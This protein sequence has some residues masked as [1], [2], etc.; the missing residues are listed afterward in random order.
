MRR[1]RFRGFR[2]ACGNLGAIV[3]QAAH[4]K[5]HNDHGSKHVPVEP[6]IGDNDGHCDPSDELT[7]QRSLFL[8]EHGGEVLDHVTA[9]ERN[10]R[11]PVQQSPDK[12]GED[13]SIEEN[14]QFVS[15]AI[16]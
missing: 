3:P 7:D 15:R 13:E 11:D 1:L 9:I 10:D 2:T 12:G 6:C 5:Y 14:S 4:G 8:A 16:E